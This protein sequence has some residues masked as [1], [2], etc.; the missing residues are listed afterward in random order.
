MTTWLSPDTQARLDAERQRKVAD[1]V[2]DLEL[3]R[4]LDNGTPTSR[5]AADRVAPYCRGQRRRVLEVLAGAK[6]LTREEIALAGDMKKDSVNGRSAEIL[7]AG[8]AR[9]EG[10]RDGQAI[11]TITATGLSALQHYDQ[12]AA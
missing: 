3:F 2:A 10:E 9:E 6:G 5:Q 12:E 11:L 1:Q 4:P 8:W 7:K